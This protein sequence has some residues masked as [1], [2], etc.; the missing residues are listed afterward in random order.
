MIEKKDIPE[1][2]ILKRVSFFSFSNFNKREVHYSKTLKYTQT[3]VKRPLNFFLK[4]V[5]GTNTP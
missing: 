3:L 5:P 4:L 1:K 2:V